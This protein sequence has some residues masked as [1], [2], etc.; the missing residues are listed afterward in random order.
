MTLFYSVGLMEAAALPDAV[1]KTETVKLC[2]R[3]HSLEMATS[4]RQGQD[5]WTETISKMVNLGA[6]GS[7]EELHAVLDYLTKFYGPA[8]SVP[9]TGS[10]RTETAVPVTAG[11]TAVLSPRISNIASRLPKHSDAE[12]I[13][14][15]TADGVPADAAK[16]WQTYGHDAGAMR[17]SPLKQLTPENVGGLKLAWAYHMR[18]P[19][20][21]APPGGRG[22]S[23]MEG[24][25]QGGGRPVGDEPE[26]PPASG[27][28]RAGRMQFGSGF[29]P[30][31]V[32]PLVIRGIMYVTTPY[33]RVAAIDPINGEEVWSWQLPSGNPSTRGVEYWPGDSK[34]SAQI[35]FGSTD[36]K[37][38]SLD[39]KTGLPNRAFGDN[40]VVNLNT[41]TVMRGLPGRNAMTSPPIVY[42]NLVITGGTTQEN[43]P[44]GPAG[45][46]RAW[47]MR[48][49][50]LVW[51]F[52]SVPHPGEKYNDTW[53]GDSWKNR[54]G[55]NVWGFLTVD[56]KRGIVYMPFGAPSVDQYGG[57]RAG[58]NL[59]SSSLV[60]ADANTGK[61][62]W[63]FQLVH[64]D[65]WDADLT[66]APALV[67]VKQG[68]KTIPAVVAMNKGGLVFLL[69]RVTGKPIYGVEERP[70]PAS[71]VPLERASKTQPFP[72]KPPPLA[73]MTFSKDEIATLTPELQSACTKLLEGMVVGG[74]YLPPA[75]NRLRVQFP[76]NHGGVN[77]GGTS[78]DPKLGYLFANVNELGQV[79][80]LR[81]HDPK[82]GPAMANGQGNRVDPNGPYE[83]F[84]GG[85]RFSVRGI[86]TQQLPCQQPP[87]GE[88]AA[89]DV[90][91]GQIA[92]KVPLGVTDNLPE[93]KHLTGR[94]GNGGTIATAG[95]LVFIGATDDSRFRAFDAKTGKEVWTIKLNGAAEATPMTYEG[96]DGKQYVVITA[97]GG[98]FF[99]NPVTDDS[100][101]AFALDDSSK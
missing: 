42:K 62:L 4:L 57:D 44:M 73:R 36:G 25:P 67:D 41:E 21:T 79:S 12:R 47:D 65:I 27:S 28:G 60:A 48:T 15:L 101:L 7:E 13:A 81:D 55:V 92:W 24:R 85:G 54:S 84:P 76:G 35:V 78:F 82:K 59:F 39:A 30:S 51:T 49:G 20:F 32:T 14:E 18:Q 91:T 66:G 8:S 70:V 93:G 16:E 3:C 63:H 95:G 26:P 61:Y 99:G 68:G 74:P 71:E 94:P 19:G 10:G 22:P 88:L 96:R 50:K 29:R 97:T 58:D 46:V 33:S 34:T 80:G 37:L 5:G 72:L 83:G 100:I 90:N 23:V 43:P 89:V 64:H 17:F 87:W 69:N 52:R 40:G 11:R 56:E 31:Q 6:Q 86:G 98:G 2:G 9:A 1:G 45:D 38:Y 53:A 77:W 75:Y